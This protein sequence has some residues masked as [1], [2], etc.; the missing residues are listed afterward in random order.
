M[1]LFCPISAKPM[2]GR[3]R[4]FMNNEKVNNYKGPAWFG[5]RTMPKGF[6]TSKIKTCAD[7]DNVDIPKGSKDS[8]LNLGIY[9]FTSG[10]YFF[11][12]DRKDWASEGCTVGDRIYLNILNV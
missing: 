3:M 8:S 6:D 2:T 9:T 4:F 12:H 5:F 1:G 7:L 10:C 11:D